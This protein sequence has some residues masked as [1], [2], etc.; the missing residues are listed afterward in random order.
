M[1]F[2]LGLPEILALLLLALLIFGPGR[3]TKVARELG[4][5]IGAFREGLR[6]EPSEDESS[7]GDKE[8]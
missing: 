3:I 7:A 1:P 2:T 5:S 8:K 6:G 4:R